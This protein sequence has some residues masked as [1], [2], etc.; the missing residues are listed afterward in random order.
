[1]DTNGHP[2]LAYFLWRLGLGCLGWLPCCGVIS[3]LAIV[4]LIASAAKGS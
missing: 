4:A 1:M 3:V 2:V